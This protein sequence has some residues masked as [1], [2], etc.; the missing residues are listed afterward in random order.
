MHFSKNVD[1]KVLIVSHNFNPGHYSHLIAS[2]KL[3]EEGGVYPELLVHNKYNKMD[4][5][6]EFKKINSLVEL[7]KIKSVTTVLIWFPSFLNLIDIFLFALFR[8]IT[9]IYV[10]HEP[11]DSLIN[12]YNS[13]FGILKILKIIL[14]DIINRITTANVDKVILPSL[15]AFNTFKSNYRSLNENF[16]Y[17]PLLFDDENVEPIEIEDKNCI[18]Y[19]GT[20]AKDHAFDKFVFLI[21]F[22]LQN[23]WFPGYNF[24]IATK[25]VIPSKE[26][27]ILIKHQGN[28]RLIIQEGEILN[29]QKIN[30]FY[31]I[32]LIVWNAYYRSM[33]S[34]V[35]PKA[36]MFG[37]AV[38]ALEKNKNE[39]IDNNE[40]GI[41]IS[42]E[43]NLEE[44]KIAISNIIR[45]KD[46]MSKKSRN[47]FLST[48]YYKNNL[49]SKIKNFR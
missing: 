14:I 23:N 31:S 49:R 19:I 24:V 8:K 9:V 11:F 48:F 20:I 22:A 10:F 41:L 45:N 16:V 46:F 44:I 15:K 7:K 4:K 5:L 32:S 40:T 39:F 42:N 12:Y 21:D 27:S 26:R 18:S 25:N 17:E 47:K 29:N 34:G 13:G 6:N 3:F 1:E 38:I 2:Y 36:Y 35:L 37:A 30:K 28:K 43:W 33:Q